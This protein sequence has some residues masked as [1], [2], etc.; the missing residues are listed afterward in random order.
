[1]RQ[2]ILARK[3]ARNRAKVYQQGKRTLNIRTGIFVFVAYSFVHCS[4]SL[5]KL[6][7]H[8]NFPDQSLPGS[9]G[10]ETPKDSINV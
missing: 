4:S 10:E 5:L 9:V 1:M 6:Y 7:S 8:L 2:S 3:G